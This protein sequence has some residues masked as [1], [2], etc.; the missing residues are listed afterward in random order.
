MDR[1]AYA[2][3]AAAERDHWWFRGRR[4]FI[5][6]AFDTLAL[7]PQ[8]RILDA[9]CGSGGNLALLSRFGR[10]W[11]FEYDAHARAVAQEQARALGLEAI[12]AGALPEAV[13][14]SEVAF[15]AIGL[16]DVLEHLPRPVESLGAL[17][18]RLAP[19]GALVLTV[20]AL[21][22]L[23]GPHD[24]VHQHQRRYTARSLREH[25]AAGGW[26][27]RYLSYFNTL[28]LPLALA[29][30]V[31]ERLFGYKVEA[32]TPSP[33]VNDALY[34]V[35]RLEEHMV[36][37]RTLPIGLSLLAIAHADR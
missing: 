16:F 22:W 2:L 36:P 32:L 27:V 35:W 20:P 12:A 9:G 4:H 28:L 10:V 25:L 26:R 33:R 17:R 8:A 13:P 34:R 7:A 19:G 3:M 29:Q 37:Q 31:K 14:F 30:R 11:G 6:R 24:E 15:D 5:A 18:E 21:P 23:W 1:D